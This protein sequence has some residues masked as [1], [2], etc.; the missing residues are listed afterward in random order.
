MT[1]QSKCNNIVVTAPP[2]E[3]QLAAARAAIGQEAIFRGYD[4]LF[5]HRVERLARE[6]AEQGEAA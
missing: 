3:A 2:T 1:R 4:I 5:K 6:A